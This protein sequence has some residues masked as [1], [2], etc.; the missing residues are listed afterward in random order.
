MEVRKR[1]SE[2]SGKLEQD[3][4]I[5]IRAKS[6]S[7]PDKPYIVGFTLKG[8]FLYTRCTCPAGEHDR[9][10]R[11]RVGVLSNDPSILFDKNEKDLISK[12]SGWASMTE[13]PLLIDD[14]RQAEKEVERAN[15][16]IKPLKTKIGRL[17]AQGFRIKTAGQ[18]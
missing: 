10:C 13:F 5:I 18:A 12:V 6:Q 15:K 3:Q 7:K 1:G 14:L 4:E 16:I 11:H 17:L 2:G 8:E 9:M